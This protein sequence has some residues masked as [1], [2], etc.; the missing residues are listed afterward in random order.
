MPS[1]LILGAS[2]LMSRGGWRCRRGAEYNLF[3][4]LNLKIFRVMKA[5]AIN[6]N[7]FFKSLPKWNVENELG[8]TP[9][10]SFWQDFSIA[11][12]ALVLGEHPVTAIRSTFAKAFA[13]WHGNYEY[14]T[15]LVLVLNHKIWEH[16]A[17]SEKAKEAGELNRHDF[18]MRLAAEY[19]GAW[20]A[21]NDWCRENLKDEA[22]E[23]F[24]QITD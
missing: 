15:E 24:Y 6:M 13:E 12:A 2:F 21:L 8:Y 17:K 7:E 4:L 18:E 11:D 22:L 19:D 14:M 3:Y 20:R 5:I 1:G 16:H 9:K 23:Y 10:T